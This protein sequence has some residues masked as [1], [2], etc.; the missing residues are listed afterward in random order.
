MYTDDTLKPISD[1][2]PYTDSEGVKYQRNHPKNTIAELSL[3]TETLRPANTETEITTG[4]IIDETYTQVWQTRAKTA[5][6]LQ[7]DKD[8][9][10]AKIDAEL[11]DAD[12]RIIRPFMASFD[13]DQEA[14]DRVA[15]HKTAQ[16]EKRAL[17][18]T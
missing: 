16:A 15:A 12:M 3:V 13:G 6:E 8:N 5:E 14:I 4:F 10:N 7:R 2:D 17:K 18:K 9:F 11:L 1:S